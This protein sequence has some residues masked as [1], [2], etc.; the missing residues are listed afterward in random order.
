MGQEICC[1][2]LSLWG[3]CFGTFRMFR[4]FS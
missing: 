2:L 1:N 4:F 3:Y